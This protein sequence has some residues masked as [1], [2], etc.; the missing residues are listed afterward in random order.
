[1]SVGSVFVGHVEELRFWGSSV[2]NF[3]NAVVPKNT[4]F[5][6]IKTDNLT[7][8][9]YETSNIGVSVGSNF[10]KYENLFLYPTIEINFEELKLSN[11]TWNDL[12]FS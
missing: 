6:S 10:E 12:T 8:S 1:M 2:S 9:G 3:R 7:N 5:K 11:S 4:S